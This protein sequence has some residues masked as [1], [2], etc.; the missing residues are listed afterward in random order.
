M[1][2][3]IE[4]AERAVGLREHRIDGG[5]IGHVAVARDLGADLGRQRLDPLLQRV[6]LISE[7]K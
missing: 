5:G 6:A 1:D 2:D 3:E 7:R 4:R